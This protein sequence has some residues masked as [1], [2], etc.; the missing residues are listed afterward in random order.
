M[1]R[2]HRPAAVRLLAV[3]ATVVLGLALAGCG[4]VPPLGS[5]A[6]PV[7]G[8]GDVKTEIRD[9]APFTRISVAAGIRLTV[10]SATAQDVTV[11][12]QANLL[13]L[14]R[15]EVVDGQLIVTVQSPGVSSSQPMALSVKIPALESVAL[16]AGST[17]YIEFTGG[18]LKLDVS[19]GATLTA[20]GIAT[21]LTLAASTGATANLGQLTA[22]SAKVAVKDGATVTITVT[23]TAS[24]TA[25]GGATVNLANTPAKVT[26]EAT[27]GAVVRPAS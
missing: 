18:A 25:E 4:I 9:L 2:A 27:S 16:S 14:I 24:G 3:V 17:G 8:T 21:D 5:G 19:G 11:G 10:G 6:A 7:A 15:T 26:I 22:A 20:I 23:G 13:P 12:A 1:P